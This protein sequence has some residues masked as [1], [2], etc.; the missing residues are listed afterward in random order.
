MS[1]YI[2]ILFS[3]QYTE[4][5]FTEGRHIKDVAIGSEH[6]LCLATDNTIWAWGWNEH[7]NTGINATQLHISKP[8]LVPFNIESNFTITRLYCGSA[9]NFIVIEEDP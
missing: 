3:I 7:A 9:H 2:E 8:T 4:F 5:L 6:A 1:Q